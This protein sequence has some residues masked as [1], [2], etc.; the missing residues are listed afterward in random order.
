MKTIP[1]NHQCSKR[2][3]HR[4]TAPGV[5]LALLLGTTA[6]LGLGACDQDSSDDLDLDLI[7]QEGCDVACTLPDG[8]CTQ[9]TPI[10]ALTPAVQTATNMSEPLEQ[11]IGSTEDKTPTLEAGKPI[12]SDSDGFVEQYQSTEFENLQKIVIQMTTLSCGVPGMF[13]GEVL[14]GEESVLSNVIVAESNQP[15]WKWNW[16]NKDGSASP[17]W[18]WGETGWI[19][20]D[21]D[22]ENHA[23]HPGAMAYE[24]K[25][26]YLIHLDQLSA[27]DERVATMS[28]KTGP[29]NLKFYAK[30]IALPPFSVDSDDS[31]DPFDP[32]IGGCIE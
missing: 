7:Q 5:T 25:Y 29:F 14:D 16:F 15:L 12:D 4:A 31:P 23:S 3:T 13:D 1:R 28:S 9:E 18:V 11:I 17:S 19:S 24:G 8:L 30:T 26:Y 32:L 21:Y 6:T 22:I 10:G 20:H 2:R 27:S